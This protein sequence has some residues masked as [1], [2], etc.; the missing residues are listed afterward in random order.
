MTC[1]K[2]FKYPNRWD[3]PVLCMAMQH[4]P[5]IAIEDDLE[6]PKML[7]SIILK[8]NFCCSTNILNGILEVQISDFKFLRVGKL[9]STFKVAYYIIFLK[10][11]SNPAPVGL[12]SSILKKHNQIFR[13]QI[14]FLEKK[15]PGTQKYKNLILRLR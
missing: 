1:F 9:L 13:S 14:A 4:K 3:F 7:A 10:F 11:K 6:S 2:N 8:I 12:D 5:C 15:K